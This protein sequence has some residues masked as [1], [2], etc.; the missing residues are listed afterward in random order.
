[1]TLVEVLILLAVAAICGA[2]GQI[3]AGFSRGG[4]IVA[5]ILGFI[6]AMI[7]MWMARGLNLPEPFTLQIGTVT[8]PILWSIIG[9]TVFIALIGLMTRRTYYA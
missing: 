8:F 2:I 4:F 1:M 7:G 3:I 6:G 5:I 9:S